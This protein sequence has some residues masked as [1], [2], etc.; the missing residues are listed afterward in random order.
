MLR[1]RS[2]AART[3]DPALAMAWTRLAQ[4]DPALASP[5]FR[6]GYT[7]AVA[8]ERDGV[9]VCVV[10]DGPDAVGFYPFERL[11]GGMGQPV[12]GAMS[13]FQGMV[14]APSTPWSVPELLRGSMLTT[15]T[16]HHQVAGQP[17]FDAGVTRRV[18]SPIIDLNPGWDAYSEGLRR[19]HAGSYSAL[20]R[21]M[22]KLEREVGPVRFEAHTASSEVFARLVEWKRGQHAR[23]G[24]RGSL[25]HDWGVSVLRRLLE[26]R[27]G[28][29]AGTLSAL[30]AGDRLVA[31]HAGIRTASTWHYW[32]PT[33]D[34]EAGAYSPGLV[35]MFEMCR[36]ACGAGI[37]HIDLGP[38]E[39][40]HKELFATSGTQVGVGQVMAPPS[41]GV[42]ARLLRQLRRLRLAGTGS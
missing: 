41:A 40:P 37:Q 5:F 31:V 14:A 42:L 24:S 26:E 30:H 8:Q 6:P 16:F 39:G 22:R 9:E 18:D 13:N 21:K 15:L 25:A 4:R 10:T 11:A 38:G 20:Q 23:T 19:A 35:L 33:Y 36:W 1:Y 29:F 12:G 28:D 7:Q 17:P 2:V 32:F 27:P 34:P 3:L